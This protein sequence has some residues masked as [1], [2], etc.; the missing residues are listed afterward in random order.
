MMD[1]GWGDD[2]TPT[3]RQ[4]EV[5][6]TWRKGRTYRSVAGE[7]GIAEQTVKNV[8][9]ELRHRYKT[10]NPGLVNRFWRLLALKDA[11]PKMSYRRLRYEIDTDYRERQRRVAREGMRRV[12]AALGEQREHIYRRLYAEQDGKCAICDKPESAFA[13]KSGKIRR[14]AIDHDNRTGTI[15]QLLCRSCNVMLGTADDDPEM[16]RKAIDYLAKHAPT[17][18]HKSNREAA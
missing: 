11:D 14:L 5:L 8:M 13:G 18:S 10:T 2:H 4:L 1:N 17:T 15:R 9:A 7:L 6:N 3:E 16:L 12:R